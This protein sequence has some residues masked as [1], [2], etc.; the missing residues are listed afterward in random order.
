MASYDPWLKADGR[1]ADLSQVR[2]LGSS[3]EHESMVVPP[4]LG[5]DGTPTLVFQPA[6]DLASGRLLGFEALLRCHDSLG[7]DIPPNVLVPWAEAHGRMNEL[8]E[9]VLCEACVQASRWPSD[10]QLA[11]NCSVFQLRRGTAA[12]GAATALERSGLNPDRLTV[13]VTEISVADDEAAA[14][15]DVMTKLGIQLTVDDVG[16]DFSILENLRGRVVNTVKID[17]S[18]IAGLDPPDGKS[19]AVVEKIVELSRS[20]G[21]CTVAEAVESAGQVAVLR[22]VGA[23]TAQGYFF[24]VPLSAEEAYELATMNPSPSFALSVPNPS[25]VPDLEDV[26]PT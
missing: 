12:G 16:T 7:Q 19:R 2:G 10:F 14:D 5:L 21:L 20:I 24:S 26:D 4:D 1:N 22:Q 13:E 18:L 6:V 23:E 9:W 11:V 15:L 3:P 17:A 25:A 8:N